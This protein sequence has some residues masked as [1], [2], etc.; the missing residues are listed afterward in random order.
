MLTLQRDCYRISLG[1]SGT[2]LA[3]VRS[4]RKPK[5]GQQKEII[6]GA[7]IERNRQEGPGF[8]SKC[9][10]R[11]IRVLDL[12]FFPFSRG[13]GASLCLLQRRRCN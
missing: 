8:L 5:Y 10:T 6:E 3:L 9:C 11:K 12:P 2:A 4:N 1:W 13:E 7:S